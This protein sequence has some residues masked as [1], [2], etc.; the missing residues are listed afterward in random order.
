MNEIKQWVVFLCISSV[1]C[2][3]IEFLIP[4][5]KM[6]KTMNMVLGLFMVCV[7]LL[8]FSGNK[9]LFDFKPNKIFQSKKVGQENGVIQKFNSQLDLVAKSNLEAVISRFLKNLGVNSNKIEIFMDTNADN[10][11]VMIRCKI[12]ISKE[13]ENMKQKIDAEVEEKLNIKTEVIIEI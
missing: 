6:G 2:T 8:P 1:I 4:P 13:Y 3:I 10:C 9:K 7:F 5:G 12:Y 11:I